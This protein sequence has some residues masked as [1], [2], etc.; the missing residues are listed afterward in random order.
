MNL[1]TAAQTRELDR[2]AIEELGIP[3]IRLMGRAGRAVFDVVLEEW[4]QVTSLR[5]FCGTGNNGG[6]GFILAEL[7]HSRGISVRV[8]Q[9]GDPDKISADALLAQQRML[10]SGVVVENWSP[11]LMLTSDL[12]PGCSVIVDALLG[13]GLTGNVRGDYE[14]AIAAINASGLPV[15]AVDIPSGLCSDGGAVLGSAVRADRTTSFI[16]LKQGLLT[17][18]G[19]EHCGTI[20]YTDLEV[21]LEVFTRVASQAEL[22]DLDELLQQLPPRPR[23]AHKGLSGSVLVLG[24]DH[25]MGGAALM[26]AEAAARCGAGLVSAATRPQHVSAF[27]ARRPEIMCHGVESAQDISDLIEQASV[28]AVGPGLGQSTW[29]EQLLNAAADSNKPMVVD[30]DALNLLAQGRV[31]ENQQRDNWIL[32]PHPG[33]AARLLNTDTAAIQADRFAAVRELQRQYGGVVLLKGAGSLIAGGGAE[34]EGRVW[35]SSYGNPGMA[36]GGMGDVL[37]GVLAGLVAQGLSPL[38]SACLG[39]CLH[40]SAAE[41]AAENGERGLLATDLLAP[42]QALLD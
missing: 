26:A 22:L 23:D 42:M 30:A 19:P 11:D 27:I 34:T 16:G 6:D 39:V 35:V 8:Y 41:S 7:A 1:Y 31:V 17:G 33:E 20:N 5:V 37:S 29:S 28:I 14:A 36:S 2:I 18:A 4:P 15:L 13:T 9:L 38:A 25:G 24:G 10:Q 12:E 3:G 40:G 32:T 21:P